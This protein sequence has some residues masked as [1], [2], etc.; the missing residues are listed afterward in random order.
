[1]RATAPTPGTAKKF[2]AW[3]VG[4]SGYNAQVVWDVRDSAVNYFGAYRPHLLLH[5]GDMAY[6]SGTPSE[7][8]TNFFGNFHTVLRNNRRWGGYTVHLGIAVLAVG[9]VSSSMF[10]EKREVNVRVGESVAIGPYTVTLVE[11]ALREKTIPGEPYYKDEIVFRVTERPAGALP[12]AHGQSAETGSG[13]APAVRTAGAGE[14]LVT[15]LRPEG[16]YY[17]KQTAWIN[18]VSI[19][20]MLLGDLYIYAVRATTG[21]AGPAGTDQFSLTVFL[22]PLMMLI[23]VGWFVLIAGA[24]FAALPIPGSRVGLSD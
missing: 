2:R 1:M 11:A 23:F 6:N 4:D 14:V 20:R 3:V 9:I 19:H 13:G 12:V 17:P 8:T 16:R 22:N 7:F 18:E 15:E 24:V 21:T 10:Q 5:M